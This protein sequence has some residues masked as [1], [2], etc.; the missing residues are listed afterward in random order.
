[1]TGESTRLGHT[2]TAMYHMTDAPGYLSHFEITR[3]GDKVILQVVERSGYM[4]CEAEIDASTFFDMMTK[5]KE[6]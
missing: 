2:M 5:L 1:M 6:F 3:D 4:A